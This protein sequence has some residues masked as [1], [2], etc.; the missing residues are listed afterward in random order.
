MRFSQ[1]FLAEWNECIGISQTVTQDTPPSIEV[2]I[3]G[4]YQGFTLKN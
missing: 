4:N 1:V 3:R 2:D